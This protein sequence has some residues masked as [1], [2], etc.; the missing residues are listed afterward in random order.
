[1]L[2]NGVYFKTQYSILKDFTDVFTFTTHN[3]KG[4]LKN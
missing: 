1:M 3:Y 4:M 2:S